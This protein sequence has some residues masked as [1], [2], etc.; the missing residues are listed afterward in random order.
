MADSL[1]LL[2]CMDALTNAGYKVLAPLTAELVAIPAGAKLG[3]V[4]DTETIGRVPLDARTKLIELGI[5]VFAYD[6]ISLRLHG[7]VR[8][9]SQYVDPGC[10]IPEETTLLTGI[11]QEDVM[12]QSLDMAKIEAV[13]EGVEFII[14]HN[15]MFDRPVVEREVGLD[16]FKKL[17]WVCSIKDIDWMAHGLNGTKLEYLAMVSGFH[18]T[19]HRASVDCFAVIKL[20]LVTDTFKELYRAKDKV[21]YQ[22]WAVGDTFQFKDILKEKSFMFDQGSATTSKGWFITCDETEYQGWCDWLL[23]TIYRKEKAMLPVRKIDRTQWHSL[24]APNAQSVSVEA[25]APKARTTRA[26]ALDDMMDEEPH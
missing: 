18:Y 25:S 19:A 13:L 10:P 14:A 21:S 17:P 23:A 8:E 4:V 12:G 15:V 26:V 16:L 7:A 2:D 9:L 11:T 24:A 6:P 3:A 1:Y 5:V 22:I 20:L